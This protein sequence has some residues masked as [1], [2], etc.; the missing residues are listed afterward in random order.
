MQASA[1][2]GLNMV[3]ATPPDYEPDETLFAQSW[4]I[5]KQTGGS[6]NMAHDPLEAVKGADAIY[7][8][9]WLSMGDSELTRAERFAALTPYRVTQQMMSQA[10]ADAIFMHCLPAHRGEEVTAE[11]I[12]GPQSIVFDQAENRLHTGQSVLHALITGALTG[13]V[14]DKVSVSVPAMKSAHPSYYTSQVPLH[15][16]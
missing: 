4:A 16:D 5:A 3:T 12:D 6:L 15:I 13:T 7:T 9:A 8:D 11:V 2:V 1:M 10:S 14:E